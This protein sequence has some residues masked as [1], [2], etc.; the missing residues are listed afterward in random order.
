MFDSTQDN[1]KREECLVSS[2]RGSGLPRERRI[3]ERPL[4]VF[5]KGE[6]SGAIFKDCVLDILKKVKFDVD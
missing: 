6:T 5:T 4:E 3:M 2:I 1:S